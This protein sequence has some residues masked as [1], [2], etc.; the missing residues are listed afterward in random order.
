MLPDDPLLGHPAGVVRAAVA[1]VARQDA[2]VRLKH[3]ACMLREMYNNN[4]IIMYRPDDVQE[5]LQLP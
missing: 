2:G 3:G 4:D 1:G 5:S